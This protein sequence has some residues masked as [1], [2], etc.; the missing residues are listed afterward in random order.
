[1]KILLNVL[2]YFVITPILYCCDN[3]NANSKVNNE[4]TLA[5]TS[6]NS[7]HL[8]EKKQV[9]IIT[10][11]NSGSDPMD[12]MSFTS[13]VV[14]LLEAKTII[15]AD[16]NPSIIAK[17]KNNTNI[18]IIAMELLI[19]PSGVIRNG[20][21]QENPYNKNCEEKIIRIKISIKPNKIGIIKERVHQTDN[22]KCKLDFAVI[23]FGDL[24]FSNGKR[25]SLRSIFGVVALMND[26]K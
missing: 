6:K 22:S 9:N 5:D 4:G 14:Q 13:P 20:V 2:T 10:Q 24:V 15:D 23:S 12:Y 26:L 11:K 8:L 17:I 21:Y 19:D 25:Y 16:F 1:M 18:D 3:Q 7:N